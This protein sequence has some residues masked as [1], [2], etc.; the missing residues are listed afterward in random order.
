MLGVLSD[1][2]CSLGSTSVN[3]AY[4]V[5]LNSASSSAT[6]AHFVSPVMALE[7]L[8]GDEGIRFLVVVL[9]LA[10]F[11]VRLIATS[12]SQLSVARRVCGTEVVHQKLLDPLEVITVS[13][14]A[15]LHITG[16]Y[17]K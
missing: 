2:R 8:R 13:I 1:A 10:R 3:N 16:T 9:S 14:A 12:P 17:L 6:R 11:F 4:N 7:K 15:I 5:A